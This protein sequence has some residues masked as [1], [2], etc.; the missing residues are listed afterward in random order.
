MSSL[1]ALLHATRIELLRTLRDGSTL[2]MMG[3]PVLLY[4]A[5]IWGLTQAGLYIDE[6]RDRETL[7]LGVAD[8]VDTEGLGD[9]KVQIVP[10]TLETLDAGDVDALLAGAGDGLELHYRAGSPRSR[11][12]RRVVED[13]IEARNTERVD[14]AAV[15]KGAD[16]ALL[17]PLEVDVDAIDDAT[18]LVQFLIGLFACAFVPMSIIV[19]TYS[20]VVEL[21][22]AERERGSIETTL[23]APIPRSRIVYARV[24]AAALLGSL[25]ALGNLGALWITVLHG[26]VL[27]VEDPV[28]LPFPGPVVLGTILALVLSAALLVAVLMSVALSAARTHREGQTLAN[29][30]LL[31]LIVPS[32][33]GMLAVISE[34]SRDVLFVPIAHTGTLLYAAIRHELVATDLFVAVGLDLALAALVLGGWMATLGPTS[35]I[36]GIQRPAWLARLAGES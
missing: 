35:L 34:S 36:E 12:T 20:P 30:V 11:R 22:V 28:S 1:V 32:M 14:A 27:V 13:R 31:P 3:F 29:F 4:P 7:V 15:E 25:A 24:L 9:D 33:A 5:M 21:F 17:A 2:L 19:S 23:C 6:A 8:G 16:A 10:A 18:P 26:A